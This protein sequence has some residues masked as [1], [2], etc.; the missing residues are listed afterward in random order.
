MIKLDPIA[1]TAIKETLS[2]KGLPL[3]VRIEIQSTGCCDAS[4]GMAADDAAEASDMIE[5]MDGLTMFMCPA[6]YALVGDVSIS[7]V[8]DSRR[9]EFILVSEK[10]LNEWAGFGRCAVRL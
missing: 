6:L 1:C 9:D 10:P 5:E 2:A 8:D 7:C 4:L 3:C